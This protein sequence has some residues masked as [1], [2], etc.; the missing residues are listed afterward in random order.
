MSEVNNIPP[1]LSEKIT[2]TIIEQGQNCHPL[3]ASGF[4]QGIKLGAQL[5]L[6]HI[7]KQ[8]PYGY[9]VSIKYESLKHETFAFYFPDQY[10]KFKDDITSN[11]SSIVTPIYLHPSQSELQEENEKL[12]E[13]IV[14]EQSGL[15]AALCE[16]VKTAQ[17]YEWIG[18]GRGPYSFDDEAYKTETMRLC[19]EIARIA[20][21]ALRK[22][23]KDATELLHNALNK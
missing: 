12:R 6:S 13:G 9:V 3:R 17:G 4:K 5:A 21:E 8:Q 15:A 14:R 10:A 22:A 1:E 16:C 2:E 7:A 11:V 20:Q 19:K 18:E 23:G